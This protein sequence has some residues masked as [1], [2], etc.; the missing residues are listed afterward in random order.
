MSYRKIYDDL[1]KNIL[2]MDILPGTLISELELSEKYGIS[3]TPTRDAIKALSQEGLLEVK[4]HIGTFVSKID[5]NKVSDTIYI[6][7]CL[8][9]S[10][11]TELCANFNP[12]YGL[13]LQQILS[14]QSSLI[15]ENDT[16]DIAWDFMQ[17]D[18]EFHAKLFELAG[19]PGIWQTICSM[20]QH[21]M[22]FRIMLIKENKN[23]INDLFDQHTE[24]LKTLLKQDTEKLTTLVSDHITD[25]FQKCGEMMISN[26]SY[27]TLPEE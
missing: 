24:I 12:S 3:R 17:V 11:V 18:N 4:P 23:S 10:I 13:P 2:H 25:G 22:R 1:K 8:E 15:S 14:K 7:R 26:T 5:I 20:N 21:Y 16:V 6:R 27:F 9:Q 19:K